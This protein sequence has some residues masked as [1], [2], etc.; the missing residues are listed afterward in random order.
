MKFKKQF[1]FLTFILIFSNCQSKKEVAIISNE[2]T[3][4]SNSEPIK[5]MKPIYTFIVN[6]YIQNAYYKLIF[7]NVVQFW[8]YNYKTGEIYLKIKS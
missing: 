8:I 6:P 5:I 1:L 3:M 4:I 7:A 2:E